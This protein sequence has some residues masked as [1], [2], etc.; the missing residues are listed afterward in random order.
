VP[1]SALGR[2]LPRERPVARVDGR[3][4]ELPPP[5]PPPS[6]QAWAQELRDEVCACA[7]AACAAR[8]QE[9]YARNVG[10]LD[11]GAGDAGETRALV[12][13]ASACTGRLVDGG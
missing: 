9:R 8:V 2:V 13:E 3:V 11:F 4:A 12:R 10:R 1:S 6:P 7:D 5:S